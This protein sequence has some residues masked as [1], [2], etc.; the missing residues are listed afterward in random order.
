MSYI[1]FIIPCYNSEKTIE[2]VVN[3]IE[4]LS[5]KKGW[6]YEVILIND[7]SKDNTFSVIKK[8]CDN[9]KKVTGINMA[10]NFGQHAALMAGFNQCVGDV[11]VC[12]DDDGQTPPSEAYKLIDA[13]EKYDV[14]FAS[15]REKKHSWFRNFGS[16]VNSLML[17][18]MLNKPK[19]LKVTSYFAAKKF[20]I[21]EIK[22]YKNAFPYVT[23]LLLRTT[24]NIGNVEVEHKE[25]EVGQSGY[26]FKKLISLWSNGL[27][28]FSVKPLRISTYLGLMSAV[29]G[30]IYAIWAIINRIKNPAV[31]LGWTT[32]IV[33]LLF[34]GG[35]ILFVLGM[36][37]EYIGRIY[38]S[39]NSSPQYVIKEIVK[40][41]TVIDDNK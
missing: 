30:V 31:P 24:N 29:L 16:G 27:T 26:S 35:M 7:S 34:L 14:A 25:R 20:V 12:L 11:V 6:D 23:G 21:D 33:I 32:I 39:L 17:E 38:I 2:K 18:S 8:I 1:S 37:G 13:T 28:A 40:T 9:N 15:Y 10:R 5:T 41:E 19:E 4:E 3:D 36:I 22:K